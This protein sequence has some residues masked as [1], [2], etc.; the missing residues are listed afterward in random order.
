MNELGADNAIILSLEWNEIAPISL[1]FVAVV[2]EHT[3]GVIMPRTFS[4]IVVVNI[5]KWHS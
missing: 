4:I 3:F 5:G 1:R 2:H